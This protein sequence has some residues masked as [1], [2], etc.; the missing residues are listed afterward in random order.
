MSCEILQE[1]VAIPVPEDGSTI[2][3]YVARPEQ[4][5]T[6]PAVIVGMELYG[7]NAE[8]RESSFGGKTYRKF[9]LTRLVRAA[10]RVE[11]E[12]CRD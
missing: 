10:C 9:T 12:S 6:Y 8:I 5:G 3:A 7:V 1:Q 4:P 11:G 2:D